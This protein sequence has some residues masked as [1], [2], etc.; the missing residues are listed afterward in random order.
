MLEQEFNYFNTHEKE[1][2]KL[3]NG[4]FIA[5]VGEKVVGAF[6]SELIAYQKMK[7]KYGLGKFLLQ[8]CIPSK[9]RF[10]QRYYSR[11]AFP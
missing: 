4:K 11:V 2:V 10:I 3:Y 1:L 8:H 9:D 6:D 5:I 7:E